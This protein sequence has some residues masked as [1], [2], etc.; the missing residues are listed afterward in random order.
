MSALG[1]SGILSAVFGI[2]VLDPYLRGIPDLEEPSASI[3]DYSHIV[4]HGHSTVWAYSYQRVPPPFYWYSAASEAI[5]MYDYRRFKG[6]RQQLCVTTTL[7]L[8][9]ACPQLTEW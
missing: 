7:K 5:V 9:G 3:E 4:S 1:S 8:G 2:Q 6:S